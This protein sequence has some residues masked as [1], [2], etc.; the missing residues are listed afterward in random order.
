MLDSLYTEAIAKKGSISRGIEDLFEGELDI[1]SKW[2]AKKINPLEEDL[3][4]AA[5]DGSFNKK[6][7]LGFYFYAVGAESL[8]Y[9]PKE[10][11][12][13]IETVELDTMP[14][15]IFADDR[16]RNMMGIFEIKT[17]INAFKQNDID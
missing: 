11:L 3:I 17:A 9:T 2:K 12:K 5:G 16:L 1:E 13:N 14:N 8:I 6:K 15:Q 10:G 4:L 7:Y